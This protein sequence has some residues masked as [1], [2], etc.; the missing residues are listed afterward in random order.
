MI[1]SVTEES[2]FLAQK[3]AL[4]NGKSFWVPNVGE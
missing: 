2:R 3:A 4:R 1:I